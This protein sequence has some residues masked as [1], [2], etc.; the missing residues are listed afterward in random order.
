MRK[1]PVRTFASSATWN[2]ECVSA[3]LTMTATAPRE[4]STVDKNVSI[5]KPINS[6]A[7]I[8]G[9]HAVM[10]SFAVME[11]A[12]NQMNPIAVRAIKSAKKVRDVVEGVVKTF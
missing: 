4:K 7:T 11:D 9:R 5:Q 3:L 12:R 8:A 6:I 10:V 1:T 2:S